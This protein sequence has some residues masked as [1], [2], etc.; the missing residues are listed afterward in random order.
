M[1]LGPDLASCSLLGTAQDPLGLILSTENCDGSG[2]RG[3][4]PQG[5]SEDVASRKSKAS[6]GTAGGVGSHHSQK[7]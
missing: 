4:C 3:L 1:V 7:G 6:E 2:Q 5:D